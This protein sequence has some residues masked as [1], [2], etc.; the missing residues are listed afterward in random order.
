MA[1]RLVDWVVVEF[2]GTRHH[3]GEWLGG[4]WSLE[5]RH[6]QEGTC[7]VTRIRGLSIRSVP[8]TIDT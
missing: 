7:E 5:S 3:G 1:A 6:D 2:V 8:A 4:W